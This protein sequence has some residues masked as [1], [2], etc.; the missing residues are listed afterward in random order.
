MRK[1]F[2]LGLFLFLFISPAH[3]LTKVLGAGSNAPYVQPGF[4]SLGTSLNLVYQGTVNGA[5]LDT[6]TIGVFRV[7]PFEGNGRGYAL[8]SDTALTRTYLVNFDLSGS[9]ATL[10]VQTGQVQINTA[11]NPDLAN[12]IRAVIYD[13]STFMGFGVQVTAPCNI[14]QCLHIRRYTGLTTVFD[15]ALPGALTIASAMTVLI[16]DAFTRTYWSIYSHPSGGSIAKLD[17]S[18]NVIG[19]T[20]PTTNIA[21]DLTSDGTSVYSIYLEG[22][23]VHILKTN[24]SNLTSVDFSYPTTT[25]TGG[26]A[27]LNGVLYASMVRAGNSELNTINITTGAVTG[28]LTLGAAEQVVSGG[29]ATDPFNTKLYVVTNDGGTGARVRRINATTFVSEQNIAIAQ[30]PQTQGVGFDFARQ[31]LYYSTINASLFKL[32]KV[33]LCS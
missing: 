17:S 24:I 26:V 18:L 32:S 11:N 2:L 15:N 28:T 19:S 25:V 13:G 31:N 8:S 14:T 3:A 21:F 16:Q 23:I 7:A 12:A 4:C 20:T 9:A 22:G 27:F 5:S 29:M 33:S 10:P 30:V 1:I 6:P